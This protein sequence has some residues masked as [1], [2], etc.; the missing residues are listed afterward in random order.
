MQ[1]SLK[2]HGAGRAGGRD[3]GRHGRDQ[4]GGCRARRQLGQQARAVQGGGEQRC[5]AVPRADLRA[6][7][8]GVG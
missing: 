3:G 2:G 7:S 6:E 5:H 8:N 4:A 1:H